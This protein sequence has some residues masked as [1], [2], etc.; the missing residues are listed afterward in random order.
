[1]LHLRYLFTKIPSCDLVIVND[2][3]CCSRASFFGSIANIDEHVNDN[4]Y[5]LIKTFCRFV[6]LGIEIVT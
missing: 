1:M 6:S 3:F 5:L 4:G 2:V